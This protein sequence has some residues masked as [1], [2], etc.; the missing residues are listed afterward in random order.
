MK[1]KNVID[2]L[3][4]GAL[5]S[6][7]ITNKGAGIKS[8]DFPLVCSH[9]NDF[10]NDFY[11]RFHLRYKEVIIRGIE[12]KTQYVID[13]EYAE[14]NTTSNQPVKYIID[15]FEN[16]FKDDIAVIRKV[17]TSCSKELPINIQNNK[18]SVYLLDFNTIQIPVQL[19]VD[20]IAFSVVYESYAPEL[21]LD[22]GIDLETSVSL[23]RFAMPALIAYIEGSIFLNMGGNN[24]PKGVAL[25]NKSEEIIRKI[26][27]EGLLPPKDV[28]ITLGER[29]GGWV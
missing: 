20:G 28:Q 13:S 16:P 19:A 17:T 29:D 7:A 14:S 10:I 9:A 21:E 26:D 3:N 4:V 5:T 15:S 25:R 6:V 11:T 23:P 2:K 12:G 22:T 27:A 24:V 18:L 8:I 1:L